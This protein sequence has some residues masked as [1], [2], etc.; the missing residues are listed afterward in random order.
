[1]ASL[2]HVF[3]LFHKIM[4]RSPIK[5]RH[6]CSRLLQYC[7]FYSVR[8]ARWVLHEESMLHPA[9]TT[10]LKKSYNQLR[11]YVSA[12]SDVTTR[13]GDNYDAVSATSVTFS[14]ACIANV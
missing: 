3:F 13:Q 1:M 14:S 9:T 12:T 10:R 6:P 8:C 5:V 7:E 2:I 4:P 11:H